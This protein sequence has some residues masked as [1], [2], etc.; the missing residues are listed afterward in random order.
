M[1]GLPGGLPG[2]GW[3]AVAADGLAGGAGEVAGA[4][5]VGGVR[6]APAVIRACLP[7]CRSARLGDVRRRGRRLA[8]FA[9][10]SGPH[11]IE[12]R[13]AFLAWRSRLDAHPAVPV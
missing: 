1:P 11:D 12:A 10:L 8:T 6:P 7:V 9:A 2:R 13:C 3:R 5:G 4:V